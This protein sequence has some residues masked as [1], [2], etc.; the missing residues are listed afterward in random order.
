MPVEENGEM[1]PDHIPAREPMKYVVD[2][3]REV[4]E[5][6]TLVQVDSQYMYLVLTPNN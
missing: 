6:S 2:E 1:S 5:V 3:Y 4:C